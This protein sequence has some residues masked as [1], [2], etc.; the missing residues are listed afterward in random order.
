VKASR[1]GPLQLT[2]TERELMA[3]LVF[4]GGAAVGL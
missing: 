1:T 3:G 4:R 2:A